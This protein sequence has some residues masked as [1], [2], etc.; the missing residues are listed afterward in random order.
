[1]SLMSRRYMAD[2]IDINKFKEYR[3][4]SIHIGPLNDIIGNSAVDIDVIF[5]SL[6]IDKGHIRVRT[7]LLLMPGTEN[8][9]TTAS[10]VVPER[11][12]TRVTIHL[13]T[14]LTHMIYPI[15]IDLCKKLNYIDPKS[16]IIGG[17]F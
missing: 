2:L 17:I 5:E 11:F 15:A 3:M 8:E 10:M 14:Y 16:E 9:Y 12:N 7:R 13:E 1:M 6:R 4:S